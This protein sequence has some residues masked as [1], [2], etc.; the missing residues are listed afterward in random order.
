[1]QN[2]RC[3]AS[4]IKNILQM[5]GMVNRVGAEAYDMVHSGIKRLH[6]QIQ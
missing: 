3:K 4:I 1:M 6:V 2:E 5:Y